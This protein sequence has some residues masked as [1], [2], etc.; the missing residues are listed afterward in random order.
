MTVKLTGDA[1]VGRGD[2][3]GSGTAVIRLVPERAEVCYDLD[4]TKISLATQAHLHRGGVGEDGAALLS[5]TPPDKSGKASNCAAG[6]SLLLEELQ[7]A[8]DRFYVDVHDDE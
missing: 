7:A 1:V 8:P 4:V 2:P 6:D 5:F 3:D